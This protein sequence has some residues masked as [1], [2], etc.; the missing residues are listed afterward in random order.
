MQCDSLPSYEKGQPPPYAPDK[1]GINNQ[2]YGEISGWMS[3]GQCDVKP[4]DINDNQTQCIKPLWPLC[5]NNKWLGGD[6]YDFCKKGFTN[7]YPTTNLDETLITDGSYGTLK[8]LDIAKYEDDLDNM[9]MKPG[10]INQQCST[11]LTKDNEQTSSDNTYTFIPEC[12][13]RCVFDP[14]KFTSLDQIESYVQRWGKHST[15]EEDVAGG[16]PAYDNDAVRNY[17]ILMKYFCSKPQ[18]EQ[19]CTIDPVTGKR[20]S[21]FCSTFMSTTKE[22]DLCRAWVNS[23]MNFE[24]NGSVP[25][26]DES[27]QDSYNMYCDHYIDANNNPGPDCACKKRNLYPGYNFAKNAPGLQQEGVS[28]GCWWIPCQDPMHYLIDK[29]IYKDHF[30]LPNLNCEKMVCS[31]FQAFVD[32]GDASVEQN[33]AFISCFT[34]TPPTN[35]DDDGGNQDNNSNANNLRVYAYV[36]GGIGILLLFLAILLMFI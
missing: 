32:D 4:D 15:P 23:K 29:N 12:N 10:W 3:P 28:D 36:F 8:F 6:R 11:D 33:Q 9:T 27:V 20:F 25:W 16:N 13:V 5:T 19:N 21:P 34:G 17:D 1:L 2:T 7:N 14:T 35:N 22:G 18:E 31:N 30:G 24:R 26:N